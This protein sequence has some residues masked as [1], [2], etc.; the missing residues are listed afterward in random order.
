MNPIN[1]VIKIVIIV[2]I[3]MASV[4]ALTGCNSSN[5][6]AAQSGSYYIFDTI[7]TVKVYSDDVTAQQYEAIGTLLER[8]DQAMNRQKKG[9]EVDQVNKQ[10]GL[11][12]V[13]VSPETF[14]VVQKAL[15]YAVVSEGRFDP[16]IGPVVDLWG[17]GTDH[18]QLPANATLTQKLQLVNYNNVIMN[19]AEQSIM[20]TQPGMSIDLGAIAKGY[21]ADQIAVYL[22]SE[23]FESAMIDL[24]G[25]ILAMGTKPKQDFWTIGIQNPASTRGETIGTLRV[26]NKTVV[27]SGV[28]ERF[29]LQ[30][31]VRYHHILNPFTG[32]PVSNNLLGV[33]IVTEHSIDADALSTTVFSMGLD[34]GLSFVEKLTGVEALFITDENIVYTTSGLK[35]HLHVTDAS[36]SQYKQ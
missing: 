5:P 8:I 1:S 20:L 22:R 23:G 27:S 31:G 26:A 29:F 3:S 17:I 13:S 36:Y 14:M 11:R 19:E 9:S 10:A 24:G 30:D 25:N 33:T 28:Y 32:Y 21:A 18:A 12:A 7:V 4:V 15:E 34:K 2:C 35:D 16:T 6:A